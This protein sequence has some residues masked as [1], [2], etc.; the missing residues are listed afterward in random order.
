MWDSLTGA[1]IAQLEH[2]GAVYKAILNEVGY[3]EPVIWA[4]WHNLLILWIII[5]A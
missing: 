5:C 1:L 3:Q 2:S 4:S